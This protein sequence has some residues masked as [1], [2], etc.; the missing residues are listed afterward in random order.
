MSSQRV[1]LSKFMNHGVLSLLPHTGQREYPSIVESALLD[2]A[3]ISDVQLFTTGIPEMGIFYQ[4]RYSTVHLITMHSTQAESM[5][6]VYKGTVKRNYFVSPSHYGESRA[7]V[8]ASVT[9][10][11]STRSENS[12]HY[13][14]VDEVFEDK[15]VLKPEK[16]SKYNSE[17]INGRSASPGDEILTEVLGREETGM[18]RILTQSSKETD[19]Q[20]QLYSALVFISNSY[21]KVLSDSLLRPSHDINTDYL[22]PMYGL[23]LACFQPKRGET[24]VYHAAF[25][26]ICQDLKS[27]L[28]RIPDSFKNVSKYGLNT[29]LQFLK[30]LLPGDLQPYFIYLCCFQA[31]INFMGGDVKREAELISLTV[32]VTMDICPRSTTNIVSALF[33]HV[34]I[35]RHALVTNGKLFFYEPKLGEDE[36]SYGEFPDFG[37]N[38]PLIP[39][40]TQE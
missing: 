31:M 4:F 19:S 25:K 29:I 18:S 2:D 40:M 17:T 34:A 11:K 37:I 8:G 38:Y 10:E 16:A 5:Y 36:D 26:S 14:K 33:R 32:S 39:E 9:A 1:D 22:G 15:T 12:N 28:E 27:G 30:N 35:K 7:L 21:R 24:E 23:P 6:I 20:V 3:Y 13:L